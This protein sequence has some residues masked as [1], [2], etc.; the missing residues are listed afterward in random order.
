MPGAQR[1]ELDTAEAGM[2]QLRDE[3]RR[4]AVDGR[5]TLCLDRPQRGVRIERLAWDDDGAA[6]CEGRQV[7]Q[8]A[9]EAVIERDRQR[10]SGRAPCSA[11][12]RLRCIRCSECCGGRASHLSV[13][14]SSR[15]CMN[16]DRVVELQRGFARL[17]LARGDSIG[18]IQ[19][20]SPSDPTGFR[21]GAEVYDTANCRQPLHQ[22]WPRPRCCQFRHEPQQHVH[23]IRRA[24]PPGGNEHA[25]ARLGQR[26][27][28]SRR[29]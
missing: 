3:H 27:S 12:L 10:K 11:A 4:Y 22:N 18:Q 24:E 15:R 21:V 16:V 19:E 9:A 13:T 7:R 8:H 5:A 1:L 6:M 20:L 14:L 28:S 23:I 17:E 29:R 25:H 26:V 2:V